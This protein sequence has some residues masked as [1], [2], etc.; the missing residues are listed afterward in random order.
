MKVLKFCIVLI[1][2]IGFYSCQQEPIENQKEQN[3]LDLVKIVDI[4]TRM[5]NLMKNNQN[6]GIQHRGPCSYVI[7]TW[8]GEWG[9]AKK[10]CDGWGLCKSRWFFWDCS[11][12]MDGNTSAPLEI[13]TTNNKHYIDILFDAPVPS[14]IPVEDLAL[15]IDEE[16]QLWIE[17]LQLNLTFQEALYPYNPN[18][19]EFGGIRIYLD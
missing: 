19:G 3:I 13:D 8:D 14:N 2:A 10:N 7:V 17:D 9:R 18:L 4:N 6:N 5:D 12:K 16:F 1:F 11:G 15:A